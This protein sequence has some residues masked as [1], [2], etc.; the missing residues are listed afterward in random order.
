MIAEFLSDHACTPRTHE[1]ACIRPSKSAME[2]KTVSPSNINIS[3]R[4][5]LI[6]L[7]ALNILIVL[8]L[9]PIYGRLLFA[10]AW[11]HEQS[12]PPPS[13]TAVTAGQYLHLNHQ[14]K[15]QISIRRKSPPATLIGH[16][17]I[18]Y[19][20]QDKFNEK[21]SVMYKGLLPSLKRESPD[22]SC[23]NYPDFFDFFRLPKTER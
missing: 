16:Y 20:G 4:C 21:Y 19:I 5:K 8:I 6:V 12:A 3:R 15:E 11:H 2:I 1:A 10:V 18:P 7:F 22:I 13:A 17:E 9:V 23:G 14:Q